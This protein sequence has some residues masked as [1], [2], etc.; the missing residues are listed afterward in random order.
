MSDPS[1]TDVSA[2]L[3]EQMVD[4]MMRPLARVFELIAEHIDQLSEQLALQAQTHEL[5]V[6][7]LRDDL[8]E[9]A[10]K[11]ATLERIVLR[12]NRGE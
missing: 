7:E 6:A 2:D 3:S 5:L 10:G 8:L 1:H 12:P 9:T 11:L 4:A